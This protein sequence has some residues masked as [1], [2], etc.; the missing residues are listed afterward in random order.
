M[1]FV[2]LTS[3]KNTHQRYNAFR[4]THIVNA[5]SINGNNYFDFIFISLF[6]KTRFM[7]CLEHSTGILFINNVEPLPINAN[8]V[9][10]S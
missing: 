7:E 8:N 6:K 4:S 3:I 5:S 1:Y 9:D 2:I 10:F